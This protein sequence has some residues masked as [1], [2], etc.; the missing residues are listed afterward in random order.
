MG[1]GMV[2]SGEVRSDSVWSGTVRLGLVRPGEV[3]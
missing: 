2:W 1:L 3:W